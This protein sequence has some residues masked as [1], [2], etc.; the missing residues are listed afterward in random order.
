MQT[1]EGGAEPFHPAAF[2]LQALYTL[3]TETEREVAR[4]LALNLTDYRALSV[5]AQSG[6]V[7][8]GALAAELGATA[9]T[10]TA[11]ISRLETHGYVARRRGAGDRRQVHVSVTPAATA[12]ITDLV[13]PLMTAANSYLTALP[14]AHQAVVGDFLEATLLQMQDHLHTLSQKDDR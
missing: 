10:T 8:V 11:I 13:Q 9:A 3:A 12:Q 2:T 6:P 1:Q 5:L 14:P 4:R 7:T